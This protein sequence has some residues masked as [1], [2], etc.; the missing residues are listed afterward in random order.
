MESRFSVRAKCG[1]LI[2]ES[3]DKRMVLMKKVILIPDSFK[4]TM[5]SREICGILKEQV[6]AVWP[7]AQVLSVPV[8]DGGEGSV[9]AFLSA[10][11]GERVKIRVKGPYFEEIDSFYGILPD[12]TAVIEMAAAAGLPLVGERKNPEETTTYGVGQLMADALERGCRKII[13]GLGGS[14]TNDGGCG[15]AAAL[16]IRFLDEKGECFIPV[17]GT[18][19]KIAS[20]DGSGLRKEAKEAEFTVMCDIDNPLCGEKGAA[21]VFAPQKGADEE[22]VRRL[23]EGLLHLAQ[24]IRRDLSRD[25]LQLPGAGAAGGMGGGMAAFL[26]GRL[27]MGI[28][29]VL[30][31]ADFDRLAADADLVITGEGRLDSQS[32]GGKAVVG[33]AKRAKKLGV[34]V[35]VL[36]GDVGDGIEPVYA[37]GV[38]AVFSINRVAKPFAEMKKRAKDDLAQ[39]AADVFRLIRTMKCKE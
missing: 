39:T 3:F 27:Q 36:A 23:D 10:L 15:A 8:A 16:G 25:I 18:L 32:L 28:E 5:S 20:V 4:G 19:R 21:A 13:L 17:G 33:V 26:D 24:Q 38:T 31:A 2:V 12:G 35:I 1:M 37:L 34:P 9:D 29:T 7:Q 22:M 11:G 14:A 6:Q 30:D